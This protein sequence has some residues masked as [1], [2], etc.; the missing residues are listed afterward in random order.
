MF[1]LY[2]L[3]LFA[4][5]QLCEHVCLSVCLSV[6]FKLCLVLVIV[7]S[8]S[9]FVFASTYL[10]D[11]DRWVSLYCFFPV[12]IR[13]ASCCF[14]VFFKF[15]W[16]FAQLAYKSTWLDLTWHAFARKAVILI[17][18]AVLCLF[19]TPFSDVTLRNLTKLPHVRKSE[20]FE[21]SRSN[22]VGS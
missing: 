15:I 5:K 18:A 19:P 8:C 2:F 11:Q 6:C 13:C 17:L 4:D 9:L 22:F 16:H 21:N 12:A 10:G 20:R 3:Y 7:V 14:I 1:V